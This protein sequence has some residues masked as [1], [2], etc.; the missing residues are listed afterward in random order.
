[1]NTKFIHPDMKTVPAGID[2]AMIHVVV[3]GP[4]VDKW[5]SHAH[6]KPVPYE[7]V[8]EDCDSYHFDCGGAVHKDEPVLKTDVGFEISVLL[9]HAE[10]LQGY[11]RKLQT[12]L[13]WLSINLLLPGYWVKAVLTVETGERIAAWL[14]EEL[15]SGIAKSDQLWAEHRE[16]MGRLGVY[17]PERDV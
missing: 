11:S 2:S 12:H 10:H 5:L 4:L 17:V 8:V 6:E 7:I 16:M 14:D 15:R 3:E 1:M 9:R 13:D